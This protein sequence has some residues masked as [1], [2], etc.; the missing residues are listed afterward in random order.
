MFGRKKVIQPQAEEVASDPTH[1]LLNAAQYVGAISPPG[2]FVQELGSASPCY[3]AS[4]PPGWQYKI[5]T[6][7][8]DG[9]V[10]FFPDHAAIWMGNE[11]QPRPGI[12]TGMIA[13]RVPGYEDAL[14]FA[15]KDIRDD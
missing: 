6:D 11:A 2:A 12:P 7:S 9:A 10:F 8:G 15:L 14:A 13:S 3:R 5:V 4:S 1:I